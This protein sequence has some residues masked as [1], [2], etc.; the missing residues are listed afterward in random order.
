MFIFVEDGILAPNLAPFTGYYIREND[1]HGII[2]SVNIYSTN[3]LSINPSNPKI[4][5]ATIKA[6]HFDVSEK[7]VSFINKKIDR[8]THRSESITEVD[9]VLKLIKPETAANK[10][11]QIKLK[12]ANGSGLFASKI[13]DTFE[14]AFD[15]CL[16]ALKTQIEKTKSRN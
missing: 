6:I 11:V 4:M 2:H 14:E 16:D 7:L 10:E 15:N 1:T 12:V 8:L 13:A 5:E 3:S 9:V